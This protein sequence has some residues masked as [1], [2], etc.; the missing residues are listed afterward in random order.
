MIGEG[1]SMALQSAWLLCDL[2]IRHRAG[3]L[4]GGADADL[5]E[6]DVGAASEGTDAGVIAPRRLAGRRQL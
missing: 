3:L 1:I 5:S 2:L 6:S 4:S